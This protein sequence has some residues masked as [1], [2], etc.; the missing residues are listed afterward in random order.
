[1]F[2]LRAKSGQ[3]RT[4]LFA[5]AFL[6]LS[7]PALLACT[8][9]ACTGDTKT[10][11]EQAFITLANAK[12]RSQWA[13]L[14]VAERAY[15][16][17]KGTEQGQKAADRLAKAQRDLS[18]RVG[19]LAAPPSMRPVVNAF[20]DGAEEIED[21]LANKEITPETAEARLRELQKTLADAGLKDCVH[22]P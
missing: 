1:M 4:R 15:E 13:Q 20:R 9:S 6:I 22:R 19:S 11:T 21:Q 10:V 17:A 5:D 8:L 2:A 16:L 12:C 3:S 18:D 7:A 14:E